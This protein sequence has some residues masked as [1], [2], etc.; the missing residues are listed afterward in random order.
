[1]SGLSTQG[2]E[3]SSTPRV[4]KPAWMH[5]AELTLL[6]LATLSLA[7]YGGDWAVFLLRGQPRSS[8]TVERYLVVPLKGKKTEY[9]DESGLAAGV[10]LQAGVVMLV[11]P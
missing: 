7:L 5:H 10:R 9:D 1:M 2:R 6:A 4:G 3:I 11:R 8:V